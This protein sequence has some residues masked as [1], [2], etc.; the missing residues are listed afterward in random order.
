MTLSVS[1]QVNP[2][3]TKMVLQTDATATP[4]NNILGTGA[5]LFMVDIYNTSPGMVAYLKLWD[6]TAV[7]VGTTN[8]AMVLMMPANTR[9]QVAIPEGVD[10]AS[11]LSMACVTTGG[12]PG[13]NSL[14][15]P[16]VVRLL[17]KEI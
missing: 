10:F 4:D 17:L 2:I 14:D 11:G 8:P 1:T 6:S 9:R 16:V 3:A 15:S 12:T 7:T 13:T 5:S